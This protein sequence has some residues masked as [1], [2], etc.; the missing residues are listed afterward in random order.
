MFKTDTL[1]AA[2]EVFLSST[3]GGVMPV[4]TLDGQTV[5]NGKPGIIT[6]LLRN[7]YWEAH[8]EE[9][10]TTPVEYPADV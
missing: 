7:R 1:R 5:G 3:A 6:T 4:T 8:D 10:W 2:D 9:R